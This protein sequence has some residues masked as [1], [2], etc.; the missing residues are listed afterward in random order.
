[1]GIYNALINVWIRDLM[2]RVFLFDLI[3]SS[4]IIAVSKAH[5]VFIFSLFYWNSIQL[6]IKVSF[7]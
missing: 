5:I 3:V 7:I 1:M 2:S 6:R 4:I